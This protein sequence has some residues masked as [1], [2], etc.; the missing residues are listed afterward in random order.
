M[1]MDDLTPIDAHKDWALVHEAGHNQAS[2]LKEL[3]RFMA[4]CAAENDYQQSLEAH[5]A[6]KWEDSDG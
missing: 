4:R 2:K 1:S 3:V 6:G 5:K